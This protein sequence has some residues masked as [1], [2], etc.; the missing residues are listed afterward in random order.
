MKA[1]IPF[2]VWLLLSLLVMIP[3]LVG[4]VWWHLQKKSEGLEPSTVV[5]RVS[6]MGQGTQQNQQVGQTRKVLSPVEYV[7]QFQPRVNGL[8]YTAPAYDGL[9]HLLTVDQQRSLIRESRLKIA[10]PEFPDSIWK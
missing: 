7:A 1:S 10:K 5:D 9:G 8:A 2:K 3:A 6:N 4:Y